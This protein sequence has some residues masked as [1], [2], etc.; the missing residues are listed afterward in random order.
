MAIIESDVLR[1][2][3]TETGLFY[4]LRN[5]QIGFATDTKKQIH[6]FADGTMQ[7]F[8]PEDQMNLYGSTGVQGN[9]GDMGY[10]GVQGET[11]LS[12]PGATGL[13]GV[14][15]LPGSG[16]T[17]GAQGATGLP[18]SNGSQGIQG[19]TGAQG[20][21]GPQ[22][23]QGTTGIDGIQG[24]QGNQG[25]TGSQGATGLS[26]NSDYM[27]INER[28]ALQVKMLN[29]SGSALATNWIVERKPDN[30]TTGIKKAAAGS[31]KVVGIVDYVQVSNGQETWV[32]VKG[33]CLVN[34]DS[35][36][37]P[38]VGD[39]FGITWGEEG[40]GYA[41]RLPNN[42]TVSMGYVMSGYTGPTN[43]AE[44][45]LNNPDTST[46]MGY[47]DVLVVGREYP[48]YVT[49]QAVKCGP[50]VTIQVGPN[51]GAGDGSS[52]LGFVLPSILRPANGAPTL[53]IAANNIFLN[54]NSY[55][56]NNQVFG[57][58]NSG[59]YTLY[60]ENWYNGSN[61]GWTGT[62]GWGA[63]TTISYMQLAIN[64]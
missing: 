55:L 4:A 46:Q 16:G 51:S 32:T 43:T 15:G 25:E 23:S 34:F 64:P 57:T 11:G 40:E 52:S 53:P 33:P 42:S 18:G 63:R 58:Y 41:Q 35:D 24:T 21:A 38:S 22:G 50:V 12:L 36:Y 19:N 28:G 30:Y 10:T 45:Y 13:Q 26:P 62:R 9:L 37:L 56:T 20:N 59:D 1:I 3:G 29:D 27:R 49:L 60:L 47:T 14:T 48:T 7:K 39:T 31:D 61:I 2:E 54:A 8:I 6:K 17:A 5:R 44:V